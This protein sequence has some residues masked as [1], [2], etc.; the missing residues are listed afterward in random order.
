MLFRVF[1]FDITLG[2]AM[3]FPIVRPS[4]VWNTR[5]PLHVFFVQQTYTQQNYALLTSAVARTRYDAKHRPDIASLSP[6]RFMHARESGPVASKAWN[7]YRWAWRALKN[8]P[9]E[10]PTIADLEQDLATSLYSIREHAIVRYSAL[11]ESFVQCWALNMLLAIQ[12]QGD[13]PT[14]LQLALVRDFSPVGKEYVVTP[15]VPRI[16]K[17]FPEIRE[18]LSRLPHISTDPKTKE[19]VEVPATPDLNSLRTVM[20]WRDFRNHIVHRGSRISTGFA[21]TYFDFFEL[22]RAPYDEKL[23]P[24]KLG[25]LLQMPDAIYFAMATTHR[26]AVGF[27]NER[28]RDVSANRRGVI[29]LP[30]E[31]REEPIAF[32]HSFRPHPLLIDGDHEPSLAFVGQFEEV[33]ENDELSEDA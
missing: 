23:R 10:Q 6:T 14:N 3:S 33:P 9:N 18:A 4:G 8:K 7:T 26:K 24:L 21:R 29:F 31:G 2:I 27:M 20:F 19:P 12:E 13:E 17:A 15:G 32:Q 28:L 25:S 30:E 22:L 5:A 16:L 1:A 11:F